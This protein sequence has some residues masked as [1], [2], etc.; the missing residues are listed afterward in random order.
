MYIHLQKLLDDY[1]IPNAAN[2]E[3][4]DTVKAESKVFYLKMKGDYHRYLAEVAPEDDRKSKSIPDSLNK[5]QVGVCI[6]TYICMR[7]NIQLSSH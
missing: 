2:V 4:D 5:P 6:Y 7:R 1:L 3:G